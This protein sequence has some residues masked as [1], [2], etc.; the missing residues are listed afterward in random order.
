[1]EEWLEI[2][3]LH[4]VV[5]FF[6][7]ATAGLSGTLLTA[8]NY[9]LAPERLLGQ[10]RSWLGLP[11]S[12]VLDDPPAARVNRSLSQPELQ[13]MKVFNRLLG[14]GAGAIGRRL[15]NDLPDVPVVPEVAEPSAQ[16]AFLDRLAPAVAR[17]NALLPAEQALRLR[18]LPF[19]SGPAPETISLLPPQLDVI[20]A[21]LLRIGGERRE[22]P[23]QSPSPGSMMQ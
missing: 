16:Q 2:Y 1:V 23:G 20:A 3:N 10:S 18:L 8:F 5:E 19:H 21:E 11:A 4:E 22:P 13:A 7:A 14:P 17:I 15:V 9:S 6:L 12:A